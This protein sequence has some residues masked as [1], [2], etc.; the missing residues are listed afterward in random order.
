M[1]DFTYQFDRHDK[2][3][4]TYEWDNIWWEHADTVDVPRVLFIGASI[5]CGIRKAANQI[6]K[7]RFFVDGFGTSKAVDNPY[8]ADSVRLFAKQEGS[9][10]AVLFSNGLHGYHLNDETEYPY[11][12]EKMI[13]FLMDEFKNTPL[14]LVL[15]TYSK[16]KEAD[17]RTQARNEVVMRLAEKYGLFVIDLYSISRAHSALLTEDGVHYTKEGYEL[18]AEF[19]IKKLQEKV[20]FSI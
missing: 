20:C 13:T 2:N 1:E 12:Y 11:H 14:F 19:V 8:F 3:L 7:G 10:S 5:S 9:R 6:A 15:S 17:E 16:S 4:E 18:L